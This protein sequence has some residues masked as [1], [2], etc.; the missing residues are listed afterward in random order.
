MQHAPELGPRAW[1]DVPDAL[2]EGEPCTL[3]STNGTGTT[4]TALVDVPTT[5]GIFTVSPCKRWLFGCDVQALAATEGVFWSRI[6][7]KSRHER[8]AWAFFNAETC[9]S[10]IHA[11]NTTMLKKRN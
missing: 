4:V 8:Q 2:S 1:T 10:E 11:G 5:G 3:E 7:A 6:T 9:Q